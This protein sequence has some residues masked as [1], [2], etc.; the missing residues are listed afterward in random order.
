MIC[1]TV[2]VVGLIN[3]IPVSDV[4]LL[5]TSRVLY[6]KLIFYY[7]SRNYFFI[8]FLFIDIR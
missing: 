2:F 8:Y 4:L 5:K 7:F 1:I 3:F 6:L